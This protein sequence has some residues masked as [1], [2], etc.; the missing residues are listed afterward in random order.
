MKHSL[1]Q[2]IP[3]DD[4]KIR[5]ISE[6]VFTTMSK[7]KL[8]A[9]KVVHNLGENPRVNA[10]AKVQKSYSHLI[11]AKGLINGIIYSDITAIAVIGS[12]LGYD[13]V[14]GE[15]AKA[16]TKFFGEGTSVGKWARILGKIAG[17]IGA[18]VDIGLGAWSLTNLVEA[19]NSKDDA[20]I[21]DIISESIYLIVGGAALIINVL[22]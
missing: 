15:G 18:L 5:T 12:R 21:V 11:I 8:F 19:G 4:M 14:T 3:H 10:I 1:N 2:L 22:N 6:A 7:L 20:V 16:G 17:P 9:R 13:I